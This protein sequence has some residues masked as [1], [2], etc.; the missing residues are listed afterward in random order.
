MLSFGLS[1]TPRD[2]IPELLLN[3]LASNSDDGWCSGDGKE[4]LS[5]IGDDEIEGELKGR[6][7]NHYGHRSRAVGIN[8]VSP[9]IDTKLITP[10]VLV[11]AALVRCPEASRVMRLTVANGTK[12]AGGGPPGIKPS[13]LVAYLPAMVALLHLKRLEDGNSRASDCVS[14][15]ACTVWVSPACSR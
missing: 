2:G 9:G 14:S 13:P 3:P 7:G 6:N 15:C 11:V 8:G 5:P 4:L 12:G 1:I 10:L